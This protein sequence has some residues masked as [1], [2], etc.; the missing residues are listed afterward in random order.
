MLPKIAAGIII[1]THHDQR[2]VR[3]FRGKFMR[4][5]ILV[6]AALTALIS[7][8][9]LAA[10]TTSWTPIANERQNFTLSGTQTVRFGVGSNWVIKTLK[11]T[12]PCT[13]ANF[14]ADPAYGKAKSCQLLITTTTTAATTTWTPVANERQNFTLSGTKTVRFGASS[15]WITK[16]LT[17]TQACTHANFGGDPAYGMAKSCQVVTTATASTSSTSTWNIVA[18]EPQTFTLSGTQTVRFGAGSSWVT[19]TLTGTQACTHANFGS[20]PAYGVAKSCQVLTTVAAAKPSSY[21]ASLSWTIPSTRTNGTPLAISELSGY[22]VYYTNDSGSVN[23][24]V[25]ISG[26]STAKAVVK[27]LASGKYYFSISAIDTGGQKSSLSTMASI[28]FP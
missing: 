20:D 23:A 11:G 27:N 10:T 5:I 25:P 16:T 26:G 21:N 19:K 6:T 17:G 8:E 2:S 18:K 1:N 28:S 22:E 7:G 14:G 12:Q 4:K 9:A 24:V 3:E 13:H 15:S